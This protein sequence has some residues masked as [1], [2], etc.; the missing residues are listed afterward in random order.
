MTNLSNRAMLASLHVRQWTARKLDKRVTAEVNAAHGA[1]ADAGRYNKSLVSRDALAEIQQIANAARGTHYFHTAPWL[2]DGSRILSAQ[3][4]AEY[5]S[6]MADHRRDFESAVAAFVA[7][8]PDYVNAARAR[9]NGMFRAEDYPTPDMIRDRFAFDIVLSPV[10]DSADFRVEIGESAVAAIRADIEKRA[11]EALQGAMRDAWQR[12]A[13]A[14]ARMVERLNAYE[15][16]GDGAKAQGVFR[17]SLVENVRELVAVLPS[18]N[19]TGDSK[20]ADVTAKLQAE[21]CGHDA[22]ELRDSEPLRKST[23]DAAARILADVS[24]YLA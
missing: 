8:Y 17:D 10:P 23:A 20:L 14:L 24:A 4:H 7:G 11:A 9:L 6:K 22:A 16:G 15:P 2:D 18:L 13:D 21:L 3:G 12:I 1:A 5:A 19:L